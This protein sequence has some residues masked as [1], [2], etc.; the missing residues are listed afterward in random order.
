MNTGRVDEVTGLSFD[1]VDNHVMVIGVPRNAPA[2]KRQCTVGSPTRQFLQAH[3]KKGVD[4]G[5]TVPA[6]TGF[7]PKYN[8]P[9]ADGAG[10]S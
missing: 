7:L 3:A 9:L 4:L 2:S 10:C 5:A 8:Q 1:E 6:Y